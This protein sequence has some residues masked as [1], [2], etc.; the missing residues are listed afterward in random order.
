[1]SL[2]PATITSLKHLTAASTA[3]KVESKLLPPIASNFSARSISEQVFA[4][5]NS[6]ASTPINAIDIAAAYRARY[7]LYLSATFSVS[8]E[9]ALA[10]ADRQLA[11]RRSSYVCEEE[12]RSFGGRVE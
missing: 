9:S 12:V 4:A 2:S 10:E 11:P 6:A 1:M 7:A 8:P 3:S 5:P